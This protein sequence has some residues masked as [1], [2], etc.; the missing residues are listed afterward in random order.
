MANAGDVAER[1]VAIS[2]RK[3]TKKTAMPDERKARLP[4]NSRIAKLRFRA[5][6]VTIPRPQRQDKSL[7]ET[8]KLN[9]VHVREIDAPAGTPPVDW[10]LATTE[11]V[12]TREQ[13]LAVVDAYRSR[14]LIEEYFKVLKSGCAY[15]S[16]QLESYATLTAALGLFLPIAWNLLLIRSYARVSGVPATAVMDEQR[17][18]LLRKLCAKIR[19]PVPEN[20]TA[21]DVML[22]VAALGG[23][24][25]RNGDPGWQVLWRGYRD[26]L[27]A[28]E[29]IMTHE[30]K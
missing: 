1:E 23:H 22:G 6:T 12:E 14:W 11:P 15:E 13:I 19:R 18:A 24:I 28:E 20:P 7:P 21:R 27:F 9:V 3:A 8:L 30:D 5:V 17:L 4:R 29:V 26:L 2:E 16:R 25:A 10:M